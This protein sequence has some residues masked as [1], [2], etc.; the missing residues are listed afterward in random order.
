MMKKIR[1]FTLVEIMVATAIFSVVMVTIYSAF[2]SGFLGFRNIE[3]TVVAYQSANRVLN[4]IDPGL[5]NAFIYKDGA[6]KFKGEKSSL[7]FMSLVNQEC[8]L[9]S[10]KL[11]GRVIKRTIRQGLDA[12][13]EDSKGVEQN[14]ANL[15]EELSFSYGYPDPANVQE[16]LWKD[17]WDS[18]DSLPIEV[19]V[20]LVLINN[21]DKTL[22]V[23]ERTIFLP[24]SI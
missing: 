14:V 3:N 17:K 24:A 8:A 2:N 9:V 7:E 12:L 6:P 13:K 15:V 5:R 1:A 16:L 23:F 18:T 10:Y 19:K 4:G 21:K 11:E 20:K 22:W